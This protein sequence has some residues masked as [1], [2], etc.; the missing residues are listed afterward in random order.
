MT[1]VEIANYA[2]AIMGVDPIMAFTDKTKV[3][4]IINNVY[5]PTLKTVLS[6]HDWNFALKRVKLNT[7]ATNQQ[8]D[9]W[10]YAYQ[11]TNDVLKIESLRDG[12]DNK[13]NYEEFENV[14][15]SNDN[16][17]YLRYVYYADG[18]ETSFPPYFI[19]VLVYRLLMNISLPLQ[20]NPSL[21]QGYVA[22]YEKALVEARGL[23]S[24]R[25]RKSVVNNS[26]WLTG[27][28]SP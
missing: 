9:L 1:K 5:E 26:K 13:I 25:G 18:M 27:L 6:L 16:P 12:N 8:S 22:L 17:V 19:N 15:Y 20:G 14:I 10:K 23:D 4:Q 28:G 7:L 11:E 2:L 24:I 3:A 21:F